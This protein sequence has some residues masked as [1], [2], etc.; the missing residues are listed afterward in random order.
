MIPPESSLKTRLLQEFHDAKI[1]GNSGV[2]RTW[3]WLAR[4]FYW[5][6]MK[7]DVKKYVVACDTCQ[8]NK[9][10]SRSPAGFLQPLPVLS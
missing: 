4:N 1:G 5:D 9:S 10:E 7:N 3:K 6:G 2:L 8:R